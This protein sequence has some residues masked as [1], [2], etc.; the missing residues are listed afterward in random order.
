[1][2][3]SSIF[4]LFSTVSFSSAS[5]ISFILSVKLLRHSRD[6]I[7]K[8]SRPVISLSIRLDNASGA[9]ANS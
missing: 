1:M 4:S 6:I 8:S 2:S 7:F 5:L 9:C 3:L